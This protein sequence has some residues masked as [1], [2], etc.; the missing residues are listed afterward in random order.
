MDVSASA[1]ARSAVPSRLLA[2]SNPSRIW[3]SRRSR[4]A[5]SSVAHVPS[6]HRPSLGKLQVLVHEV[7]PVPPELEELVEVPP[8]GPQS[9]QSVPNAHR[10]YVLPGP[11]SSQSPSAGYWQVSVQPPPVPPLAL[12][13]LNLLR[14]PPAGNVGAT[15]GQSGF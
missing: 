4:I 10:L 7:P 15:R 8:R 5:A 9:V 14:S 11:P 12:Q 3:T 6:S 13:T 1:D 2:C